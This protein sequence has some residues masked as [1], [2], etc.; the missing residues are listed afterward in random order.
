MP[1][2]HFAH[3][4]RELVGQVLTVP[5]APWRRL[6]LGVVLGAATCALAFAVGLSGPAELR[7]LL[8]LAAAACLVVGDRTGQPGPLAC[9]AGL[10]LAVGWAVASGVSPDS[11]L[12]PHA[13]TLLV[14]LIGTLLL[15]RRCRRVAQE[16]RERD[17]EREDDA[18]RKSLLDALLAVNRDCLALLDPDARVN[19]LNPCGRALL[20]LDSEGAGEHPSWLHWWPIADRP[21]AERRLR[22]ALAGEAQHFSADCPT[23]GGS[24]RSWDIQLLP[25]AEAQGGIS[26]VLS[27]WRDISP[28]QQSVRAASAARD[29][30]A[31]LL[32][33]I[34]DAFIALDTRWHIVYANAEAQATLNIGGASGERSFWDCFPE[35]LGTEFHA[36]CVDSLA[37]QESRRFQHFFLRH[38][39]WFNVAIY[40]SA[41][42]AT[43][44]IRDVT[45]Q[46]RAE[47][48]TERHR[49]RLTLAQEMAGFGDWEYDVHSG[50]MT[51]GDAA[52]RLLSLPEGAREDDEDRRRLLSVIAPEQRAEVLAHLL[53]RLSART[54]IDT[55]FS[56]SA[57]SVER[58]IRMRG[59]FVAD[60]A[61]QLR[62]VVG[63]LHDITDTA[64][65]LD[66]A[67]REREFLRGILDALPHRICVLDRQL[68]LRATNR[69]W[70]DFA[71]DHGADPV[72]VGVGASYE[73][74]CRSSD[75]PAVAALLAGMTA[76][77]SGDRPAFSHRY[78]LDH[79]GEGGTARWFEAS[80]APL[81]LW[82]EPMLVVCH[83]DV[84]R[85]HAEHTELAAGAAQF[86]E[87]AECLPD[88]VFVFDPANANLRYLS[89]AW[90]RLP[91]PLGEAPPRQLAEL[92]ERLLD[93]DRTA[94]LDLLGSDGWFEAPGQI[95]LNFL[96]APGAP[97]AATDLRWSPI[98][99]DSGRVV[100][101]VG[102]LADAGE[103][104]RHA[105]RLRQAANEDGLT[106]LPSKHVLSGALARLAAQ[107]DAVPLELLLVDVDRL[108]D[109][110]DAL[111]HEAGDELLRQLAV[112]LHQVA[113]GR[114][115]L[116][117]LGGDEFAVLLAGGSDDAANVAAAVFDSLRRPFQIGADE[118]PVSVGIGSA[119]WPEDTSD[120][121][122]LLRCASLALGAAKLRGRGTHVRYRE[123]GLRPDPDQLRL[124]ADLHRALSRD[125]F[126]LV[127]QP[128]YAAA[129]G[130]LCGV[131]AL[132]RWTRGDATSVSP[133]W[134][135]PL[136]EQ[137]GDIMEVGAWVLHE[138]CRQLRRWRDGGATDLSMAVNV[139]ARQMGD[140][141]IVGEVIAALVEN[142]LDGAALELEITESAFLAD[143]ELAERYVAEL[144]SHGVR[145]ALDDFGTGFSS[146]SYL[147]RLAPQVLKIDKSFIDELGIDPAA[148]KLVEGI[149]RMAH[150]LGIE[151]VAEGVENLV[152]AKR[153]REFACDQLQ[154]Y[155][156]GRPLPP[157]HSLI[158]AA[159][160]WSGVAAEFP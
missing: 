150:A 13:G 113:N 64:H 120:P 108:K 145:V 134:F 15:A 118:L 158:A 49:A 8:W 2:S 137:S 90:T 115:Q 124:Q 82:R 19:A 88:P 28:L 25:V 53:E 44:L 60:E 156:L 46:V 48:L 78:L 18:H 50:V 157:E 37:L 148:D 128:K 91:A 63:T 51:L 35:L 56:V 76:L 96:V 58:V 81:T 34:D 87:L 45:E 73:Q 94:L 52:A 5:P 107:P 59:R 6:R 89:H 142:G 67:S 106:G 110:N 11:I 1:S 10:L 136:L 23:F 117:R 119:R 144:R 122:D 74:A 14:T 68:V 149:I 17:A 21:E 54:S 92:A 123:S 95:T 132:L 26:S 3:A 99:D 155:L 9:L 139:S 83:Q 85:Q 72:K 42:G 109:I 71:A 75:D 32:E 41:D 20:E 31:A 47:V 143:P 125:E 103:R 135:V 97:P 62:H 40:P 86:H 61:G 111:G 127:Y 126:Q 65:T 27:L 101:V 131:E 38:Q 98:R 57:G 66:S 104:I 36:Q 141:R 80:I 121:A 29:A 12:R 16:R 22:A 7:W 33:R 116:V 160:A 153:L 159:P 4:H 79:F 77:L 147:R 140:A 55:R 93:E 130:R 39:I 105:E 43:L 69:A 152:Q 84:S 24:P 112:R 30:H 102:L 133:A 154:G 70:D 100:R 151:V 114:W 129:D 146:L 138:A